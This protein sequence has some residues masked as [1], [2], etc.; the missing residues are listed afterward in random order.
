MFPR[1]SYIIEV[2]RYP[3]VLDSWTSH[4]THTYKSMALGALQELEAFQATRAV[5]GV[6]RLVF[7]LVEITREVIA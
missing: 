1:R 4:S 3:N 6:P 7:R 5:N 2:S